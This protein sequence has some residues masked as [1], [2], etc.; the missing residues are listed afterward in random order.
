VRFRFRSQAILGLGAAEEVEGAVEGAVEEAVE[1]EDAVVVE[2]AVGG[3]KFLLMER[4]SVTQL[5]LI[6]P[7]HLRVIR[8]A[9]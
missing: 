5:R 1:E 8:R 7:W 2:Q 4:R 6:L 9:P 3:C